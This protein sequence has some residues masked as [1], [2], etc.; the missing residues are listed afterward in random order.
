M[1][2]CRRQWLWQPV[3][4]TLI[5][6]AVPRLAWITN[7]LRSNVLL[8]LGKVSFSFYIVHEPLLQMLGWKVT[9]LAR[10]ALSSSN[11]ALHVFI[12][13]AAWPL[14]TISVLFLADIFWQH[15]EI[16]SADLSV[17]L[18]AC[19]TGKAV[20]VLPWSTQ[21]RANSMPGPLSHVSSSSES[22]QLIHTKSYFP[23]AKKLG[24]W[25]LSIALVLL[26]CLGA[27][28]REKKSDYQQPS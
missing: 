10:S 11:E 20:E 17:W 19:C 27:G 7:V 2:G 28:I 4:A 1:F 12:V 23:I 21:R 26:L 5:T 25:T 22:A 9:Y 18:Q 14:V 15:V 16:P 3:G 13:M 8:Y 24:F 6:V